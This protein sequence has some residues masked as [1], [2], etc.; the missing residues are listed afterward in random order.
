MPDKVRPLYEKCWSCGGT[1]KTRTTFN[2]GQ[3]NELP[4][5]SPCPLCEDGY[6]ETG[7]SLGQF[8]NKMT[9]LDLF[10]LALADL[11]GGMMEG[12]PPHIR[13]ATDQAA[14]LLQKF[15][16]RVEDARNRLNRPGWVPPFKP[17]P[18]GG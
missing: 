16:A 10:M 8:E 1:R 17:Q 14:E 13:A 15:A 7:L 5:G 6:Y 2:A 3:R 12:H 4:A 11:Y 9:H 18:S